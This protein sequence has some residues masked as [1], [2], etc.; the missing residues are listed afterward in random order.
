MTDDD[1]QAQAFDR[2]AYERV[3]RAEI[4][5]REIIRETLNSTPAV[6]SLLEEKEDSWVHRLVPAI[7]TGLQ[8]AYQAGRES[9]WEKGG[10]MWSGA[11][12]EGYQKGVEDAM[13]AGRMLLAE[14]R[15]NRT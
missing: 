11:Y 4:A 10:V 1:L 12:N 6:I 15:K 5:A 9:Q 3:T 2:A 7:A 13:E 8:A 14:S